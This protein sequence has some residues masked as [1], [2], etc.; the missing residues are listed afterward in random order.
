MYK[1][2]LITN[3]SKTGP[4]KKNRGSANRGLE[5]RRGRV[6]GLHVHPA[7]DI[8]GVYY[9]VFLRCHYDRPAAL[10]PVFEPAQEAEP[11]GCLPGACAH[12]L[13]CVSVCMYVCGCVFIY[14][15]TYVCMYVCSCVYMYIHTYVQEAKSR[16]CLAGVCLCGLC[17]GCT[18]VSCLT[19]MRQDA[20]V[21]HAH[22]FFALQTIECV[23]VLPEC[24]LFS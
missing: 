18:G 24:V 22:A 7:Q 20:A 21:P 11:L 13:L 5:H 9:S 14:I 19:A 8:R 3:P 12:D 4:Q 16:V 10:A 6:Y 2:K 1:K 17:V 23:L 15:H